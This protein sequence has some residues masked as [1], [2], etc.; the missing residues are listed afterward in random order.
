MNLLWGSYYDATPLRFIS[1]ESLPPNYSLGANMLAGAFAG[2]AVSLLCYWKDCFSRRADN[3]E[4]A[5]RHV[6]SRSLE[7]SVVGR[8]ARSAFANIRRLGYKLSVPNQRDHKMEHTDCFG[9]Y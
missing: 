3:Y 4:G 5:L 8:S 9:P 1:F 2:I 6:S 7:G